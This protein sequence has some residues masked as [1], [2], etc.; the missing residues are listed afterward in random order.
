MFYRRIKYMYKFVCFQLKHEC[1][2]KSVLITRTRM[3]MDILFCD[4]MIL[5]LTQKDYLSNLFHFFESLY[6]YWQDVVWL[7]GR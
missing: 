2:S 5:I 6:M 3:S 4:K 7:C 1:A